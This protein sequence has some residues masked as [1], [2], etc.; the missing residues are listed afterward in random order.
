MRDFIGKKCHKMHILLCK[1]C[2]II[3]YVHVSSLLDKK[4][5]IS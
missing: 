3:K 2:N 5:D 4:L 1:L